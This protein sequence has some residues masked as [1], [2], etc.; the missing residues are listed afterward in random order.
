MRRVGLGFSCLLSLAMLQSAG[1]LLILRFDPESFVKTDTNLFP[2]AALPHDSTLAPATEFSGI[3]R[4]KAQAGEGIFVAH[5]EIHTHKSDPETGDEEDHKERR[6]LDTHKGKRP[7]DSAR[8]ALPTCQEP[9][10]PTA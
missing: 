7:H 10:H 6:G 3:A 5:P 2:Y 9:I 4:R 1:S 8:T